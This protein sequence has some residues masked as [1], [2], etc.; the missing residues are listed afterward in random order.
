MNLKELFDL[1]LNNSY[2]NMTIKNNNY[3]VIDTKSNNLL[4]YDEKGKMLSSNELKNNYKLL[5]YNSLDDI[6]YMHYGTGSRI[7]YV[8]NN[9]FE[10]I[11][12]LLEKNIPFKARNVVDIFFDEKNTK[13]LILNDKR[14]YS[15]DLDG[16]FIQNEINTKD[17]YDISNN[18]QYCCSGCIKESDDSIL[19]FNFTAI[20]SDGIYKYVAYKKDGST[21][22]AKLSASGN[23]IEKIYVSDKVN[24]NSLYPKDGNLYAIGND[25]NDNYVY[26]I[27]P[28]YSGGVD[29]KLQEII[30]KIIYLLDNV[31]NM[32]NNIANIVGSEVNKLNKVIAST[33]DL[34]LILE[35]NNSVNELIKTVKDLDKDEY[36]KL[37]ELLPAIIELE[38][39][40]NDLE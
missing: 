36:E 32:E 6:F 37:K 4:I 9:E 3:Y 30:N 38:K 19:N 22:I 18:R 2:S 16:N 35:A 28:T 21:Y 27:S 40:L 25:G 15:I 39:Y 10:E 11:G 26:L 12:T 7:H 14:A 29:P 13:Y 5:A 8:V 34:K 1:K 20:G 17:F 23:I 33:N 24:I 31:S